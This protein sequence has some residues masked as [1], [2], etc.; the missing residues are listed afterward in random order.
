MEE[1]ITPYEWALCGN[2]CM[3]LLDQGIALAIML[4]AWVH[5]VE[6]LA[7]LK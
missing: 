7:S 4:S 6:V 2:V 1:P 5:Y 3:Y